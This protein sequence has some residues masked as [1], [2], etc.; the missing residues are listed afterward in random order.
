M[1]KIIG[2]TALCAICF[3]VGLNLGENDTPA[4][5]NAIQN[6]ETMRIIESK[7]HF[8]LRSLQLQRALDACHQ[9]Q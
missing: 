2:V 6:A 5:Q 3:Y 4:S 1:I 9:N 8:M 7:N